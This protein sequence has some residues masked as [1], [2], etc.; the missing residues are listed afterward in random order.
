MSDFKEF[1]SKNA[2]SYS[3]SVSHKSG[4]DLAL[5]ITH[6]DLDRSQIALDLASGTGFTAMA[7]AKEVSSVVAYDGTSEMLEQAKKL[8]S[9]RDIRNIEYVI[10]D[11]S[12]LP[13]ESESFDIVTCRRAAHHFT[14]KAKFLSE[15]YRVLKQG[16]KL[17]LVDMASPE[18][19]RNDVFNSLERIRDNSHVGAEKVSVWT[20]L[21]KK[22][23]F[24][25]VQSI[26]SEEE[27]TLERW[28]S[29]VPVDGEQG[30]ELSEFVR[31]TPKELLLNANIDPEKL[32]L[33]KLRI[34]LIAKK[35]MQETQ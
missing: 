10:G 12:G 20:Q 18:A 1:F 35:P 21:V 29:P 30:R 2:E 27:Y 4:E 11:V 13:F 19:D 7:L 28:L 8:A 6:L 5:L 34:T 32:T 31:N 9:E 33:L 17:G 15:A 14:D 24:E 16:G 3:K 22:S 23:G 26:G 25:I